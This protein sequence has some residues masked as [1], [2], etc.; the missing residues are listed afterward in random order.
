MPSSQL[1]R[2]RGEK[3]LPT[4][5]TSGSYHL[6]SS[7]ALVLAG[8]GAVSFI[9]PD[10]D[11]IFLVGSFGWFLFFILRSSQL[12]S[13]LH[14]LLMTMMAFVTAATETPSRLDSEPVRGDSEPG[15]RP[16]SLLPH[17]GETRDDRDGEGLF[18]LRRANKMKQFH[19]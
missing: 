14:H 2:S 11:L 13:L 10:N 5:L 1:P 8:T 9:L 16:E 12:A 4:R 19:A 18:P 17:C 6:P 3:C 15:S 7:P